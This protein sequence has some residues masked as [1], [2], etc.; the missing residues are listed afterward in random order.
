[1][2]ASAAKNRIVQRRSA[3]GVLHWLWAR[4]LHSLIRTEVRPTAA[5]VGVAGP[6]IGFLT[7]V[8]TVCYHA[9]RGRARRPGGSPDGC[10]SHS[11]EGH[12]FGRPLM[13]LEPAL[14]G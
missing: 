13:S 1:M 2:C 5:R 8:E 3:T 4:P 7:G 12:T 9:R 6:W 10:S 14:G 11:S